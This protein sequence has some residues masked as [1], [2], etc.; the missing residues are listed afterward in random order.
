M[1]T[2]ILIIGNWK[3]NPRTLGE[4]K[5]ITTLIQKGTTPYK[6]TRVLIAPPALYLP[7][8]HTRG[9]SLCA[10]D[11]SSEKEGPYT[12]Q[13]SAEMLC[14][15]KVSHVIVGHS[16]RRALGETNESIAKKI[17]MALSKGITPVVCVGEKDR[18]HGMWYLGEV[19]TQLEECF[20]GIGRAQMEKIVIAY[21]PV[22]A[23]SSSAMRHDATPRDYEEMQI[24]IRK[25]LADMF[26]A[27]IATSIP[28]LY[29]GSVDDKNA[30]RFLRVGASGLL[31]GKASLKA[32]TFIKI[33]KIANEVN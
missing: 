23:I 22:W 32:L 2:R 6:N 17:K 12:G 3:M 19:K 10:Q 8:L 14:G 28:I 25:V 31:V 29:G 21:E 5:K 1:K 30:E 11:V 26:T 27:Q 15:A 18:E 7:L 20:A 16:E 33:V 9:L 13:I 24:Y 4:A